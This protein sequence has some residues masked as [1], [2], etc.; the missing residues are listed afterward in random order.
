ARAREL[1]QLA[2]GR[3]KGA[4]TRERADV[5]LVDH[6][7]VERHAP[8]RL[9]GPAKRMWIDDLRRTVDALRLK[10]RRRIRIRP[11]VVVEQ[12]LIAIAKRR[13]NDAAEVA[14]RLR[15]ERHGLRPVPY[16]RTVG[17]GL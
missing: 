4:G 6:L 15:I 12:K 13:A 17:N 11:L 8:P 5:H 14:A 7:T 3:R 2:G 1:A 9:I 16:V 10:A